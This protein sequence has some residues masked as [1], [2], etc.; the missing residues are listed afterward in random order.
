MDNFWRALYVFLGFALL[1]GIITHAQGFATAAGSLFTGAN[2]LGQTLEAG[3]ISA[4]S[5]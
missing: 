1:I 2:G 5:K 3:N 4:G